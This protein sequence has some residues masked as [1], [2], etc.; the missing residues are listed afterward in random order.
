MF[1]KDWLRKQPI[2][3]IFFIE[4]LFLIK[5]WLEF[6]PDGG[7]DGNS[8]YH[9]MQISWPDSGSPPIRLSDS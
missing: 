6:I 3:Y 7:V 8:F 1:V 2:K 9:D 4:I 5:I